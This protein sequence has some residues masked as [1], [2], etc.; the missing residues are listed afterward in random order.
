[1][2]S[3]RFYSVLPKD[4]VPIRRWPGGKKQPNGSITMP[5]PV[6]RDAVAKFFRAAVVIASATGTGA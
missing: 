1:M 6:Y 4:V 5:R 3:W 2:N